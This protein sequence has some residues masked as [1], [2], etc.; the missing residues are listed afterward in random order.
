[1]PS[2]GIWTHN[3]I[4]RAAADLRLRPGGHWDR[5]T[6]GISSRNTVPLFLHLIMTNT[7]SDWN[8]FIATSLQIYLF[9]STSH[10]LLVTPFLIRYNHFRKKGIIFGDG[11]SKVSCTLGLWQHK[12]CLTCVHVFVNINN[13]LPVSRKIKE[14]RKL[15]AGIKIRM[16]FWKFV[17]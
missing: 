7:F 15:T 2:G 3:L 4:K 8:V 16:T 9:T 5:R 14:L 1:M 6:A 11:R 17:L 12:L 10:L 13:F